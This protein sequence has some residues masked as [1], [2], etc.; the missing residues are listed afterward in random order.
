MCFVAYFFR[1]I[2]GAVQRKRAASAGDVQQSELSDNPMHSAESGPVGAQGEGLGEK[3]QATG[4]L[5]VT[6]EN[7]L[8]S[9]RQASSARCT[10]VHDQ[11][12]SGVVAHAGTKQLYHSTEFKHGQHD[13]S[14][15][16]SEQL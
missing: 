1:E 15:D 9:H 5:L 6:G 12:H 10:N 7:P 4:D 8:Y 2:R 13:Q 16:E 3:V 14:M 11:Q